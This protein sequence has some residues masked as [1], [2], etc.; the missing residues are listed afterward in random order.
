MLLL[1]QHHIVTDGWSVGVLV[2]EL[3]TLYTGGELPA[4]TIQY[5]DFALWQRER[6]TG[7]LRERHLAY[8]RRKLAGLAPLELPT[9][10]PRPQVRTT[11]GAIRRYDLPADLVRRL[12]EIGQDH[13]ATLFMTLTAAVQLL[14]A[15]YSNQQDVAVG[16]VVSGRDHAEL[17]P[18]AG[19]FVNTLVLRSCGG[20][21]AEL[22]RLP[23]PAP[24]RPCWRRS[25]TPTCRSTGWSRTSSRCATRAGPRWC[26]PWSCCR[27]TWCRPA[28]PEG[29]ASTSTTCRARGPGSTWSWS[30]CRAA[31]ASSRPSSTTPTCSTPSTIDR[32]AG[33]LRVLLDGIAADPDRTVGELPLLT[34]AERRQVL[35]EWH[36]PAV[37][38]PAV[39]L[40]ELFEAAG[41]AARRTPSPCVCEGRELTYR[42]LNERANR[43][44]RAL[45]ARGAGPGAARGALHAALGADDR[46][47]AG[48]AEVRRRLPAGRPGLPGRAPAS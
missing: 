24:R 18:V 40:P 17:E 46:R 26:R 47:A 25:P 12:S 34:D 9:D 28:R 6:L 41:R 7:R 4:P 5:A 13:G 16:T 20:T 23:R 31:A 14:F 29:C 22:P 30:S 11:A 45:I 48:R 33:H 3:V 43:L 8:W 27:T 37:D 38:V 21:G 1:C 44:A 36:G 42:E 19:F 35:T 2:D 32:I 10:R 39:T 15:R